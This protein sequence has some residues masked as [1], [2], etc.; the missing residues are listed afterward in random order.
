MAIVDTLLQ[1]VFDFSKLN[2]LN[3]DQA[4]IASHL[5]RIRK[6]YRGLRMHCAENQIELAL[7]FGRLLFETCAN[8][9]Y[10]IKNELNPE[11]YR[12]F[13]ITSYVGDRE[14]FFFLKKES[15]KRNL[16]GLEKRMM[17]SIVARLAE[18]E[19]SEDDLKNCKHNKV[20]GK[21]FRQILKDIGWD[22]ENDEYNRAYG[23]Y[24]SSSRVIHVDWH[25]ISFYNLEYKDG[26]YFPS[27]DFHS[28]DVRT[29]GPITILCLESLLRYLSI[30][31]NW[32]DSH[33]TVNNDDRKLLND[34]EFTIKK[35]IELVTNLDLKH[36]SFM[37][38][39]NK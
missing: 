18:N 31:K 12:S 30:F 27:I 13:V 19:I 26:I 24:R 28:V 32:N 5:I 29:P 14:L 33:L 34:F 4:I 11:T 23:S 37:Q 8:M 21:P 2:G 15:T 20:D 25:H 10:M 3:R 1:N 17:D 22:D 16:T 9:E 36:E 38:Q 35:L 6:L 7:I 39:A